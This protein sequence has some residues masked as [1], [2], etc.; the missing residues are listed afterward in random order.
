MHEYAVVFRI[1]PRI[2][3]H[4][5]Q[6]T[7]G[8]FENYRFRPA[9]PQPLVLDEQAERLTRAGA[10]DP[11]REQERTGAQRQSR[12]PSC[13]DRNFEPLRHIKSAPC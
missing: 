12:I 4:V 2:V 7:F 5:S 3:V 6:E 10:R 13:L 9:R 8:P 11:G 1:W